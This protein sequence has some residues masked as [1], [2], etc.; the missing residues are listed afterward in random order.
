MNSSSYSRNKLYRIYDLNGDGII[1]SECQLQSYDL[2]EN[3]IKGSV[4]VY[5]GQEP[6]PDSLGNLYRVSDSYQLMNETPLKRTDLNKNGL[7]DVNCGVKILANPYT[8]DDKRRG[9]FYPN[10]GR[11]VDV[12]RNIPVVLDKPAVSGSVRPND[13]SSFDNRNYLSEYKSYSDI[14]N[15]QITYYTDSSI[16]Q[17]FNSPVYT[18]SSMVDKVIRKDPMDSVKPEYIKTPI[19]T[20]LHHISRDQN[21]RDALSH[22]EDLMS[23]QQNLYNRTSW[24]NRWEK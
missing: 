7:I 10:D 4:G 21:T 11:V 5:S 22:R 20:T 23:R 12:I 18:I 14:K 19:S 9:Y 15:G 2:P 8:K 1:N 24:T 13:V 3:P 6:L 17:P 16:D